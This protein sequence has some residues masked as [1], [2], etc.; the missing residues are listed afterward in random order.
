MSDEGYRIGALTAETG[1]TRKAI[2][3]YEALGLVVPKRTANGYRVYD[4]HQVKLVREIRSLNRL[5]VPLEAMRPF[6]DCLNGGSKYADACPATLSEYRRVI[7]MV[8]DTMRELQRRRDGLVAN[9]TTASERMIEAMRPVDAAN[10][11]LAL[12]RELPRP[13]DDGAA[14]HLVGRELPALDLPSTDGTLTDLRNA[15]A[16]FVLLYVFPMTGAPGQDMPDGW[17]S[18]PGARGCSAHNCDMRNHYAE[19]VQRG[20]DRVFGLSSQP[21]EYQSALADALRLPYPLLADERLELASDPGLP[22][23][24]AAGMTLFRRCALLVRASVIEHVFYPIF[25]PSEASQAVLSWLDSRKTAEPS[26]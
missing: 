19:L 15:C 3:G 22:T 11:N 25:P 12:P 16:G 23:F 8:D 5:G 10:P 6:V 14:D 18:I 20:V 24:S 13:M 2:L 21:M 1:A 17:D 4:D 9:L 26:A 7:D